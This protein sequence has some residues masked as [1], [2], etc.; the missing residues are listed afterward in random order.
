LN[1]EVHSGLTVLRESGLTRDEQWDRIRPVIEQVLESSD[2]NFL[3]NKLVEV[4]DGTSGKF[5]R[6]PNVDE[7]A[8]DSGM[9]SSDIKPELLPFDK[10]VRRF[11]NQPS[12]WLASHTV[13]ARLSLTLN[14]IICFQ[15]LSAHSARSG[16][17]F[18]LPEVIFSHTLKMRTHEATTHNDSSHA[19]NLTQNR[20]S[21]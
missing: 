7:H 21:K 18:D 16:A 19:G 17:A 1:V 10:I 15:A 9:T 12:S 5:A 13:M 4:S 3:V 14:I 20:H 8:K 6:F 11:T 2:D